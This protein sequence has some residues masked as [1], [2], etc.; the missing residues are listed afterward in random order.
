MALY[1]YKCERCETALSLLRSIADRDAT[2]WCPYC[3]REC[4]RVISNTGRPIF[5]CGG[6]YETDYKTEGK[7]GTESNREAVNG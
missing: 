4:H 5:K 6:F 1:E 7:D 3:G 2:I